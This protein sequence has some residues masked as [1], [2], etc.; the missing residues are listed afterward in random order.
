MKIQWLFEF[1]FKIRALKKIEK[2]KLKNK[3]IDR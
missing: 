1:N 2:F 3:K